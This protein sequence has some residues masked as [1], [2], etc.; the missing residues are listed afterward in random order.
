MCF[1]NHLCT[2]IFYSQAGKKVVHGLSLPYFIRDVSVHGLVFFGR[3]WCMNSSFSISV[4]GRTV[5]KAI[6]FHC[7]CSH[8][9]LLWRT[10][11]HECFIFLWAVAI[12]KIFRGVLKL[13]LFHICWFMS[14][15]CGECSCLSSFFSAAVV[16]WKYYLF[17]TS[18]Y[19]IVLAFTLARVPLVI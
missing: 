6:L 9:R 17:I 1:G 7:C 12:A 2:G 19:A 11:S 15:C 13:I 14:G 18:S 5:S 8:E 10:V 16:W 4:A 3:H